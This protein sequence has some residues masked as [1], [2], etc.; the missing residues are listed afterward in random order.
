MADSNM[1]YGTAPPS[2]MTQAWSDVD[3]DGESSDGEWVSE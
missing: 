1:E 2:G 3:L